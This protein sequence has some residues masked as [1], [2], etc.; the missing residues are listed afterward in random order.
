MQR[1]KQG[2]MVTMKTEYQYKGTKVSIGIILISSDRWR[3]VVTIENPDPESHVTT[4]GEIERAR[5]DTE[6]E[7]LTHITALVEGKLDKV[8]L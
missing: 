5:F 6:E 2:M 3:F 8:G 4:W 7:L 1:P